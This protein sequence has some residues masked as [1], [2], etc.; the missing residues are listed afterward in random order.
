MTTTTATRTR[1]TPT[2][3]STEQRRARQ[4]ELLAA[5]ADGVLELTTSD[6]WRRYLRAMATLRTYST[7]NTHIS[8][9]R[10]CP[11]LW[12]V[13]A[14][15]GPQ[16]PAAEMVPSSIGSFIHSA[17][18]PSRRPPLSA[19]GAFPSRTGALGV[20]S[21]AS[22]PLLSQP[23]SARPERVDDGPPH[24]TGKDH[25]A[26]DSYRGVHT[27]PVSQS[28]RPYPPSGAGQCQLSSNSRRGTLSVRPLG[29]R[30]GSN[31]TGR[32]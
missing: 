13:L 21:G 18:A 29:R 30:P 11:Q 24:A 32:P 26:R 22:A 2:Q 19:H 3:Q 7:G 4:D 31:G 17:P 25:G 28:H 6:G 14:G 12:R 23:S 8:E 5:L 27:G 10:E 1:R 16:R 20:R 15:R 9:S